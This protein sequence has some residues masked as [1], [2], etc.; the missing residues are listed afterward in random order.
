MSLRRF[1]LPQDA[2]YFL[3]LG[4]SKHLMSCRQAKSTRHSYFPSVISHRIMVLMPKVSLRYQVPELRRLGSIG[5]KL[6]MVHL[7][8]T[9]I[10]RV[11]HTRL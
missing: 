3:H 4:K 5:V 11:S 8:Y 7:P 2:K 1:R 9:R 6:P 10:M